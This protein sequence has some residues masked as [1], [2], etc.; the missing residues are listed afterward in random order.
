MLKL[1]K[2]LLIG[3]TCLLACIGIFFIFD[4]GTLKSMKL[5]ANHDPY[6]LVKKQLLHFGIGFAAMLATA[7]LIDAKLYE[8]FPYPIYFIGLILMA[9]PLFTGSIS[10]GASRWTSVGGFSLQL[11]EVAKF[12]LIVFFSH[13]M[14]KNNDYRYFIAYLT[15]PV[16]LMLCQKD[17]G[18]LLIM[19]ASCFAIYFLSGADLYKLI[20]IGIAGIL[21][22]L[23]MILASPYRRER[24]MTYIHPTNDTQ[25]EGY[26]INQLKIAIGRGGL[27]GQGLGQ[28][29][30]KFQ[31]LPEVHTDS[32]F[33]IIA[34]ETGFAGV[35]LIFALYSFFLYLIWRIIQYGQLDPG[36]KMIGYGIFVA[37]VSQIFVNLGAISGLTP[38]T[39][40]TLPFL[41]YGGSSLVISCALVGVIA[42]L[43][44]QRDTTTPKFIIKRKKYV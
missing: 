29:R 24:L 9:I 15:P 25:D 38:L 6:S 7:Y 11:S 20:P 36:L 31:Y 37:F 44:S 5:S 8:R 33:A 17:L 2:Q 40:I 19:L 35:I 3:L 22:V 4:V 27:L 12:C 26:H 34:E 23:V 13:L 10:H 42:N 41:S 43:A 16:I 39:G 21:A 18:S 32:I 28:S 14:L 30:Q 1:E